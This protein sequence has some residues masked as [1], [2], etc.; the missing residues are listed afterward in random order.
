V[1]DKQAPFLRVV[2]PKQDLT[3]GEL[4]PV[5]LKAC[6]PSGMGASLNGLPMLSGGAF[7]LNKLGD[8]P[9]QTR[10]IID[11]QP[12]N[13][14][15]WSSTLSAVEAGDHPLNLEL[16]VMVRVQ[17]KGA[18]GGRDPFKDFFGDASPF[19]DSAFDDFFGQ[20]TEK[21]LTL[22]SDGTP[23]KIRPL[24]QQGRPSDFS[25]AV[26]KFDLSADVSQTKVSRGDP[27]TLKTKIIGQGNFDRVATN[28]LTASADWK[29]YK[30]SARFEAADGAGLTGT[31]TFEQAIVPMGVGPSEIPAISFSY[32]DPDTQSYVTKTTN[33]IPIEI[34]PGSSTV[35]APVSTPKSAT[36]PAPHGGSLPDQSPSNRLVSLRPVVL[37]PWFLTGN[38]LMVAATIILLLI[39]RWRQRL[40]NHPERARAAVSKSAVRQAFSAMDEA[41]K[42]GNGPG[43]FQA[44]RQAVTKRLAEQW[45]LPA[46][47]ITPAEIHARLNGDSGK[48]CAL[49]ERG[50]QVAYSHEQVTISELNQWR[51]DVAQALNNL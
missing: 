3:V 49:F 19:E 30:P 10:E 35:S 51:S 20:M 40:A 31:K 50:D 5:E 43:F 36:A 38:A 28:G 45:S 39:T 6:F 1:R 17:E 27:I 16:P 23:L 9:E 18:R 8:N 12:Y 44:A 29:S 26:G 47:G 42:K 15:T 37:E 7:T 46:S 25:G 48:I 2:M 11:G 4:V 41:I 13:V 14:I 34:L 21:P 22:R 33:P 32:F 24:P